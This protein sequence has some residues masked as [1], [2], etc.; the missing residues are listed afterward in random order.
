MCG[1]L[2]ALLQELIFWLKVCQKAEICVQNFN[3]FQGV[4]VPDWNPLREV[5]TP[6]APT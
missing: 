2:I 5:A 6:P 3:I 1:T 4:T